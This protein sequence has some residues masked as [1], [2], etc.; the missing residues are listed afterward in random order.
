MNSTGLSPQAQQ[1]IAGIGPHRNVQSL[2]ISSMVLV[3]FDWFLT[4]D[5]EVSYIWQAQWGL[6]KVL[7]ILSRYTTL[8]HVALTVYCGY[9]NTPLTWILETK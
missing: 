7:Y 6:I 1:L 4:F 8:A 3:T 9:S 5:M 2:T